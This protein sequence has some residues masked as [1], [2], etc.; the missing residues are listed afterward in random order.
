MTNSDIR[1]LAKHI[2]T[3]L[4]DKYALFLTPVLLTCLT[5]CI[6]LHQALFLSPEQRLQVNSTLLLKLLEIL[7]LFFTSSASLVLLAVLRRQR[8]AVT[9]SDSTLIFQKAVFLPFLRV[10]LAQ[11]ICL[12]PWSIALQ[13]L[14]FYVLASGQNPS[15]PEMLLANLGLL[16][17]GLAK[18][19]QSYTY[20]MSIYLLFDQV[21]AGQPIKAFAIVKASKTIMKGHV[22][23]YLR[24]D[25]SFLGWHLLTGLT[26]GLAGFYTLPYRTTADVVFYQDLLQR[27]KAMEEQV[28]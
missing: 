3:N 24:L 12:L 17:V 18:M 6:M 22:W 9:F 27:Y 19:Y 14:A 5:L 21:A 13:I 11:W 28:D 26:L 23:R 10:L 4:T 7:T 16:L 8:E 2:S 25:W 20:R 1:R 15:S